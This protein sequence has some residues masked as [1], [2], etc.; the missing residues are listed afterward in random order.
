MAQGCVWL[1]GEFTERADARVS[2]FDAGFQHAVGLFETMSARGSE[3]FRADEH[4]NRLIRSAR[5]LGLSDSLKFNPLR[6]AVRR[7]AEHAGLERARIRL[8]VTGGDLNMLG[9][10]GKS[11]HTPTIL[12]VAQPAT[13][14][15]D[16]MF[17]RG[18]GV[19]VS[20]LRVN[21]L[22]PFEGHKT[23]NYWRRLRAL[24]TA[25]SAGAA[26]TVV[27]QVTNHLAGG[28]V[29]NIFLVRDGVLQTPIA[30][31]EEAGGAMAAPVLPGVTRGF[32]ID[33]A[34]AMGVGC[35]RKMLAIEDLLDADEVFLTNSS[36]GVLPVVQV[37]G[38]A[39]GSGAPGE[40][41]LG[42]RG[43]W[44]EATG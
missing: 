18:V 8:T 41:T 9:A 26:E 28:A 23:L 24:Q 21:P 2:A 27:L 14:Y 17:E 35:A 13:Q 32:V 20:D 40:L 39:I 5:T 15:P 6:E 16:A 22:D 1:N 29:S 44:V 7:V 36:W 25:S 42:L 11:D 19:T 31:G 33:A 4:L 10:T 38:K 43:K 30:Q 37:E 3:V 34:D 12:I